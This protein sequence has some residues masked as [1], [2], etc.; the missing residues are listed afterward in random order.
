MIDYESSCDVAL[1]LVVEGWMML[2]QLIL[3]VPYCW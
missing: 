1:F 3:L 2:G